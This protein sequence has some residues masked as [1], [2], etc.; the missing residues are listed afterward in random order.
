VLA[1]GVPRKVATVQVLGRLIGNYRIIRELGGGA[2]GKVYYAEH[3]LMGRR[4][5]IK[6]IR[7]EL[8]TDKEAVQRFINEAR[9]VSRIGH[10]NIVEITDFGQFESRY[11]IIMELLEGETLEDKLQREG[12]LDQGLAVQ[13][14]IHMADALRSAH[15]LGVVHRDLK[16]ENIFLTQKAGQELPVVKVLDFGIAKLM[17]APSGHGQ[18]TSPG[19]VLGTPQY[20]SPEQCQGDE[21]LDHRSD[22][23][24]LG[25]MLYRMLAGAVP[26]ERDSIIQIMSAHIHAAPPPL[27]M[28]RPD[29]LKHIEA[30]VLKALKK[31]PEERFADMLAFRC[32]LEG[33]VSTPEPPPPVDDSDAAHS[34][35]EPPAQ[36]HVNVDAQRRVGDR[37]A[38]ILVERIHRN[39][40]VLPAM[41]AAAAECLR[42]LNLPDNNLD[43]VL[44]IISK[45]PVIAPQ[46]MRRARSALLG[47]S[48]GAKTLDQAVTR[49]GV[50]ALRELI[51][52]VSAYQLFQSKN[53]TIRKITKSLWDHSV[54]VA[55]LA[56]GLAKRRKDVEPEQ[57]YLAGLL[58]DVG[59][60]VAASLLLELERNV[61]GP[62]RGWLEGDAW[63]GV[64]NECHREVGVALARS[65]NM[66]EDVLLAIARSDRY[67]SE[68]PASIT[69]V[70]CYANALAKKTGVFVGEFDADYNES[71]LREGATLFK[72]S[73][74]TIDAMIQELRTSTSAMD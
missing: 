68:S 35:T 45:D 3:A 39:K 41:P 43:K 57:A 60:P 63:L 12:R 56:R 47:R 36:L 73:A 16:P 28:I 65:W 74:E 32:A 27:R 50:R 13:W 66:D 46:V 38:Q 59:K 58:H 52:N 31:K 55:V 42:L 23:Y 71:L 67:M 64:I 34:P 10:P 61:D 40:L 1:L 49:L 22:V 21:H 8:S 17:C 25:V 62:Q 20:M 37:L 26:F 72:L 53:P 14:T 7:D 5:A 69:N 11:Y 19:A 51:L 4:A 54:G 6:V 9:L 24:S 33:R 44:K 48:G 15:E 30:A 70:V 18:S 29:V 2:M